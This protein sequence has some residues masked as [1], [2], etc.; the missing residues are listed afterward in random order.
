MTVDE[1]LAKDLIREAMRAKPEDC[2]FGRFVVS[3][4]NVALGGYSA[5][6]AAIEGCAVTRCEE[7]HHMRAFE[8][9]AW[10]PDFEPV[11]ESRMIPTYSVVMETLEDGTVRRLRFER[12]DAA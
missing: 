6:A 10:H 9:Y 7:M 8:Y 3:S 1:D 11:P 4:R 5:L 12:E 2:R